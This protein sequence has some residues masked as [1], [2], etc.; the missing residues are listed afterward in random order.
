MKPTMI[1]LACLAAFAVFLT[2]AVCCAINMYGMWSNHA[3]C[4]ITPSTGDDLT[5]LSAL[6]PQTQWTAYVQDSTSLSVE[7]DALPSR[8][9]QIQMLSFCGDPGRIAFFPLV[10]G[11]LP[12][13]GERG[14]CA[15]DV[16]TAYALF[17]T[18][19]IEG[20]RVRVDGGS[21]LVAGVIDVEWPFLMVSAAQDTRFNR[22]AA[23]SREELGA[24]AS[25]L[26][27]EI[28]P[29]ELSGLEVS[30][31]AFLM[32][33]CPVVCTVACALG[34]LRRRMGWCKAVS[35]FLLWTLFAGAGLAVI[36]CIPVRLLPTRWSDLSFYS[37]LLSAFRA[38]DLRL[39]DARDLLLQSSLARPGILCLIACATFW[40]ERK[41]R[42]CEKSS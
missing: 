7:N 14:V 9:T 28:D 10:S 31:I 34:T 23:S 16:N 2:L 19:D 22:L 32:C 1:K 6:Y 3:A 33:V 20:N 18:T 30:R 24:L 13:E 21:L 4:S 15:L 17:R 42:K 12:R 8:S 26:G 11:R 40:L 37:E 39:P 41:C 25:A 29:F 35:N 5:L 27:D 36:W 38:R